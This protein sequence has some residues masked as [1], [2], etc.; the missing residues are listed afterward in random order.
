MRLER[1]VLIVD[2]RKFQ[3]AKYLTSQPNG[4]ILIRS[5]QI[6]IYLYDDDD[7]DSCAVNF[8]LQLR[9][10]RNDKTPPTPT[11]NEED[12][13][14]FVNNQKFALSFNKENSL[15]FSDNECYSVA[16]GNFELLKFF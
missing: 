13:L 12:K 16:K 3:R 1:D 15:V 9:I 6:E 10:F 14:K 11:G 8:K 4:F 2:N 7:D 5:Q